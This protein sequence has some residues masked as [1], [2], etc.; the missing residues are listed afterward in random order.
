MRAPKIQSNGRQ[1]FT[2]CPEHDGCGR[3]TKNGT[4][5]MIGFNVYERDHPINT[6]LMV[7]DE[8]SKKEIV[9]MDEFNE[10]KDRVFDM[11][12]EALVT[13]TF[14][15]RDKRNNTT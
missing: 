1:V 9:N 14:E 15:V 4:V 2:A 8:C 10:I 11:V 3:C 7:C 5:N 12:P 13:A 6:R